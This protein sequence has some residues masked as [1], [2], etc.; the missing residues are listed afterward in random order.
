MS[1]RS[2][3]L[4]I[5]SELR[6]AARAAADDETR[7]LV[8]AW[9][10]AWDEIVHNFQAAADEIATAAAAGRHASI[11]QVRR[12]TRAQNAVRAAEDRITR[13]LQAQERRI[14]PAVGDLADTTARLNARQIASQFPR[15]EGTT[16]ELAVRFDRVNAE[17]L[18]RIVQRTTERITSQALPLSKVANES[19][20]RALV[21]SIPEGQSPRTAAAR[22]VKNAEGAFNGGLARAL[23][24][25]R[26]EVVDAYR[27]AAM[28]QQLANS[29]VLAGWVWTAELDTATC[30]SCIAEHGG[31]HG[32]DEF[33]PDDHQNGRCA[34]TPLLK[35]WSELGFSVAEP[36][37]LIEDGEEWF[38]RQPE[39]AQLKI[40]GP[41]RLD[42]IKS[43]RATV[44][45]MSTRRR[46]RGWRDSIVPTPIG[47]L[48][49][50]DA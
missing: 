16:S 33:G 14:L 45:D 13:I 31:E 5:T 3:T 35:P 46:T 38:D 47:D 36:P 17:A 49:L 48:D 21:R 24:V 15:S 29:D 26:T 43:G 27:G 50:A 23:T 37:S 20:L 42:A 8:A 34:R 30:P 11:G 4:K 10:R 19:M 22:M 25:A 32:L 2:D 12:M 28:V 44:A 40:M 18:D 7:A 6:Q 39:A 1:I 41:A 9:V